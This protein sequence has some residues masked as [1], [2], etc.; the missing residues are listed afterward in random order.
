MEAEAFSS[1]WA[2]CDR[3]ATYVAR[4]VSHNRT[5]SLLFEPLLLGAQRAARDRVSC[6]SGAGRHRLHR[7]A[8]R[9]RRP[10]RADHPMRRGRSR[11]LSPGGRRT[12]AG[13]RR[14]ALCRCPARRRRPRPAHR[15]SR[16][17]GRLQG[18][19]L[20]RR[21]GS[22]RRPPRRRSRARRRLSRLDRDNSRGNRCK[23]HERHVLHGPLRRQQSGADARRLD[24]PAERG[25]SRRFPR[26]VRPG[27][28]ARQRHAL[29]QRQEARPSQQHRLPRACRAG[30]QGLRGQARAQDQRRDVERGRLVGAQVR[31]LARISPNISVGRVRQALL[32][33]ARMCSRTA[34]SS[35]SCGRRPS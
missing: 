5:D 8:G 27:G 16:A 18:A 29:L 30:E 35:R 3:V 26:V 9:T 2:H 11:F 33:R 4:M 12:S 20:A 14:R 31:E 28:R 13:R 6:A 15:A 23:E 22:G 21:A 17:R 10:D 24:E 32:S 34:T 25:R 1:D 7:L 19:A